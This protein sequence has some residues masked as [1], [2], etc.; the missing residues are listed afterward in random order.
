VRISGRKPRFILTITTVRHKERG[1]RERGGERER[2][3]EKKKKGK[4]RDSEKETSMEFR[5][6]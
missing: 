3:R 1:G 5:W 4:Q 2:E 6:T